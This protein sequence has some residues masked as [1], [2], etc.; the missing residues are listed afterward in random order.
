MNKEFSAG[1]DHAPS[2]MPS[3]VQVGGVSWNTMVLL[4]EWFS[5]DQGSG[6]AREWFA[7]LGS[8]GAGKALNMNQLGF[9]VSLH[10]LL[11]SDAAAVSIEKAL[12][13]IRCDWY[14]YEGVSEQHLNLMSP[15]GSRRSVFLETEPD[16]EVTLSRAFTEAW[17]NADYRW[18]NIKP[19]CRR[20]LPMLKASGHPIW[21]DLHDYDEGNPYHQPFIDAAD[22][23]MASAE[24]L[25]SPESFMRQQ[26]EAGKKLVIVTDGDRAV[27]AMDAFG[28]LYS[29]LPVQGRPLRTRTE[30]GM[31]SVLAFFMAGTAT[32]PLKNVC[33]WEPVP[34]HCVLAVVILPL[35]K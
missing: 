23:L 27:K 14:R 16:I 32:N 11:G 19:W 18:V 29:V 34:E 25:E 31:H 21:C 6:K 30:P 1:A 3:V 28:K 12:S 5:S 35:R 13:D 4:D 2:D 24:A 7:A 15:G 17:N 22:Y 8:T 33:D 20:L 9:S 26:I 10:S